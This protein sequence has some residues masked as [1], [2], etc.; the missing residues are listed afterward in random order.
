MAT[1]AQIDANRANALRSTGPRTPEGKTASSRN[2]LKHGLDAEAMILPGEDPAAFAAL[3][4]SY[5]EEYKPSGPTEEF[6]VSVMFRAHLLK[7]RALL[8]E[9]QVANTLISE[10]DGDNLGAAMLSG[11]PAAR[12]LNRVQ[13]Q[14][15]AHERAFFR[16]V[17]EIRRLRE[18]AAHEQSIRLAC[19]ASVQRSQ[20]ASSEGTA[21]AP[22]PA[23][24]LASFPQDAQPDPECPESAPRRPQPQMP[25]SQCGQSPRH[26]SE[27]CTD[28]RQKVVKP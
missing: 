5:R 12:L 22:T 11:S 8:V 7:S 6:L 17:R 25:A 10:T 28:L 3:A 27:K 21:P 1:Q 24:K 16:A 9:A 15:A 4:A 23:S 13:N 19:R 18:D 20:P 14:I 2:A 26:T